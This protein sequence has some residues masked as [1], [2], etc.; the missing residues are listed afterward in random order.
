MGISQPKTEPQEGTSTDP[1]ASLSS[2]VLHTHQQ[3]TTD[4]ICLMMEAEISLSMGED[5]SV[6]LITEV[7]PS[8]LTSHV[9][10]QS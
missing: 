10:F 4:Y 1:S 6:P 2:Q 8:M 5:R 7:F 3:H 9:I